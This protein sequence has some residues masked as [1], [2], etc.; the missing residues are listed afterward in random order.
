MEILVFFFSLFFSSLFV[1]LKLG[2]Y[3]KKFQ[4]QECEVI[5]ICLR[6]LSVNIMNTLL[7]Y[8]INSSDDNYLSNMKS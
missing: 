8:F 1:Y 6:R 5:S 7:E 4:F 2:F 3:K